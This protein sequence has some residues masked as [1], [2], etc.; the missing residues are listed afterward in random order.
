VALPCRAS[1][2]HGVSE[3]QQTSSWVSFFVSKP[4]AVRQNDLVVPSS[5]IPIH[6]HAGTLAFDHHNIEHGGE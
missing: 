6:Y 4:C 5:C 2:G 3:Q 1:D